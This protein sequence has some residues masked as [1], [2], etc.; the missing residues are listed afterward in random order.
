MEGLEG[1]V[2]GEEENR[3]EKVMKRA[4]DPH[5]GGP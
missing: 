1:L 4:Q 5:G 3:G 2:C